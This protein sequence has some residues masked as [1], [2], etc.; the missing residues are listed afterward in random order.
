MAEDAQASKRREEEVKQQE[1]RELL[2]QA[3]REVEDD[4]QKA[5]A[6]KLRCRQD[7]EGTHGGHFGEY[8][9]ACF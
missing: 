6:R 3:R 7:N 4:Q 9:Y 2:A 1:G 5:L 8:G